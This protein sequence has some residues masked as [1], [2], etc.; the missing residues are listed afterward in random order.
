MLTGSHYILET[1]PD[2]LSPRL[3]CK[4][5][6]RH[7]RCWQSDQRFALPQIPLVTAQGLASGAAQL[8]APHA[9]RLAQESA[10]SAGI[11]NH[12]IAKTMFAW[13]QPVSPHVASSSEGTQTS[14][15]LALCS[16]FFAQKYD[17][18]TCNT[19]SYVRW[20]RVFQTCADITHAPDFQM[21]LPP[22]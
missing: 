21:A 12:S 8:L 11:A 22:A 7:S 19:I 15:S 2:R 18:M 5:G 14:K 1:G 20:Q 9:A 3:R 17:A 6:G 16:C 13:G 10:G 4:A